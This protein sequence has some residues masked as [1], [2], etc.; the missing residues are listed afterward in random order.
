MN[1]RSQATSGSSPMR[2]IPARMTHPPTRKDSSMA[3]PKEV[4]GCPPR[5]GNQSGM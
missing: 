4:M 2:S 3:T 1:T 5:K